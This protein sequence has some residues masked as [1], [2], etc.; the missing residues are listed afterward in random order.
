MKIC[1]S[2]CYQKSNKWQKIFHSFGWHPEKAGKRWLFKHLQYWGKPKAFVKKL[3]TFN[4]WTWSLR[5]AIRDWPVF[6]KERWVLSPSVDTRLKVSLLNIKNSLQ[7]TLIKGYSVGVTL[8]DR[9]T[10]RF[11]EPGL[12]TTRT[13]HFIDGHLSLRSRRCFILA[14]HC[15]NLTSW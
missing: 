8:T 9:P 12:K 1:I 13:K 15:Y 3:V 4:L 2:L 10:G 7:V 14:P 11:W 6:S 5:L